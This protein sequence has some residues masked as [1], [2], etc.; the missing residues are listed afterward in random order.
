MK[1]KIVYYVETT[2]RGFLG[3]PKKV[4]EKRVVYVDPTWIA[5]LPVICG[6]HSASPRNV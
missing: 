1:H 4:R 5:V 6:Y 3:F 2:K